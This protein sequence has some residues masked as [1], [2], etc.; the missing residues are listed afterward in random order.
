MVR[1]PAATPFS[2]EGRGSGM[3]LTPPEP[4]DKIDTRAD[5]SATKILINLI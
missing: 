3:P 2:D 4:K 1:P 5:R